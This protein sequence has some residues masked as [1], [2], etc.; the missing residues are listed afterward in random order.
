MLRA[1]L[2]GTVFD[3]LRPWYARAAKKAT[4]WAA[5]AGDV[6]GTRDPTEKLAVHLII[7]FLRQ[8]VSVGG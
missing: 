1:H 6:V 8:L 7:A 5:A 4:V 2:Y 3:A